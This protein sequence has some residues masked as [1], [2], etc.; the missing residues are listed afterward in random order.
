MI[1]KLS[2]TGFKSLRSVTDLRLPSMAVFFGPNTAGKSNLIDALQALSRSATCR[3]LSDA[4][5]E[6][7]RGYPAETFSFPSEG[8][9]GLLS[10]SEAFFGFDSVMQVD[11]ERYRYRLQVR[12]VP[13]TGALSVTDEYLAALTT[14]GGVRGNA[15]IERITENGGKEELRIRRKSKPAHPRTEPVGLNHTIISDL[16]LGGPEYRGIEKCRNEFAGWRAYYLDPRTA[17]RRPVPPAEVQD[18]GAFGEN[19][20]PFLYRLQQTSE[21]H[22]AAVKRLLRTL[23]PSVEG[24][25]VDL[26]RQRGTLDVT[27]RQNGV[28]F[29]SRILSEGT[30]RILAL[31]AITVNPWASPVM[32]FEEPENGVQPRRIELISNLLCSI[33]MEQKRQ[34]IVTT[35]SPLLVASVIKQA[36]IHSDQIGL[37]N[38]RRSVAGTEIEPFDVTDPLLADSEISAALADRGEDG[39]F[40]GLALRG[41]L[42]E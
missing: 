34:L 10:Q 2:V 13:A 7:I 26:D 23:V 32:A 36:R 8:L 24:I 27:V 3:T 35:H 22:F 11:R 29:S 4:L 5:Q 33:A 16:R 9:K 6:P 1:K 21:R 14:Q 15:L 18:I 42:D 37:F 39:V 28:D 12:V 41:M 38:V 31:C 17:M 25:S 40:E 20:A 19:I 30:L